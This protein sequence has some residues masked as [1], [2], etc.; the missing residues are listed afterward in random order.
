MFRITSP[1]GNI[2]EETG[3][4]GVNDW[5]DCWWQITEK[6]LYLV[7]VWAYDKDGNRVK[8]PDSTSKLFESNVMKSFMEYSTS[9]AVYGDSI[10]KVQ[11]NALEVINVE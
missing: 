10:S 2:H 7:E 5:V 8:V 4:F 6:G 11:S 1:S 9:G 3:V